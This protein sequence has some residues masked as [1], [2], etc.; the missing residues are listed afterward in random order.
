MKWLVSGHLEVLGIISQDF[1]V[2]SERNFMEN[3]YKYTTVEQQIQKLKSQRLKFNN[4]TDA[5]IALTTFGYYNIINGYRDPYIIKD[6]DRKIYSPDV[7]FEQIFALFAFDHNIRNAI[8]LS[9]IDLEEHL[10]AV[11]ADI[12]SES[13]GSDYK[14]YLSKNNYR[15]KRVSDPKYSRNNILAGMIKVAEK[16]NNQPVKYYRETHGVIPPWILFKGI[17]FGTLVNYTKFFKAAQREKLVTSLYGSQIT[18]ENIEYFKDLLS[19]TLFMC[20]EYRNLAAH[21]GRVYNYIPKSTIRALDNQG[22]HKGLPQLVEVLQL[23]SYKQP[24]QRLDAAIRHALTEY[25]SE[26]MFDIPRLEQTT[27]FQ[28]SAETRV[29]I[30]EKSRKYH[31]IEHC[32]GSTHC[33]QVSFEKA[34]ELNYEPCKKC[35]SNLVPIV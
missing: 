25:C 35:C 29:W 31:S 3:T 23:F 9:M 8:L 13:F 28:I 34:N 19:D 6:Y 17:H 12:I 24:Y 4:E 27:G 2:F 7:T 16:T 11:T 30:N 26:Y 18:P 15:D 22:V 20:C 1:F 14:I 5:K 33:K 21:G 32:S 10:R